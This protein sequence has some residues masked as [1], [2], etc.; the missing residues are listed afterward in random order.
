MVQSF[1]PCAHFEF[2]Q[3]PQLTGNRPDVR[4]PVNLQ[5]RPAVLRQSYE[6][7]TPIWL[8]HNADGQDP[9]RCRHRLPGRPRSMEQ[10]RGYQ[11]LAFLF[12]RHMFWLGNVF[13]LFFFGRQFERQGTFPSL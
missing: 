10:L 12:K 13:Q 2:A 5:D 1:I 11:T 4:S 9:G 7:A 3:I 8:L 6:N